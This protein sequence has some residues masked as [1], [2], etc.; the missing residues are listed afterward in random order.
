MPP[1]RAQVCPPPKAPPLLPAPPLRAQPRGDPGPHPTCQCGR[2]HMAPHS[3]LVVCL[4]WTDGAFP[5]GPRGLQETPENRG[6]PGLVSDPG[7]KECLGENAS[8]LDSR[9]TFLSSALEEGPGPCGPFCGAVTVRMNA[10]T[11]LDT[12]R[13]A[14]ERLLHSSSQEQWPRTGPR[15]REHGSER[16]AGQDGVFWRKRLPV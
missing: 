1:G 8:A 14:A 13:G 5:P 10:P 6:K 7:H 11:H 12:A 2:L 9:G 16:G 15:A 3:H 4:F